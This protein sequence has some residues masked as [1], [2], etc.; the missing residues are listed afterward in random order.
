MLGSAFLLC[1]YSTCWTDTLVTVYHKKQLI[2]EATL[3]TGSKCASALEAAQ[4]AISRSKGHF[5]VI[6]PCCGCCFTRMGAGWHSGSL[7][8]L[9]QGCFVASQAVVFS[10]GG[11]EQGG[12][13]EKW[14]HGA[15]HLQ[16]WH[17]L[18][19]LQ[20]WRKLKIL[21]KVTRFISW[22]AVV[23]SA[24]VSHLRDLHSGPAT[25]LPNVFSI[26]TNREKGMYLGSLAVLALHFGFTD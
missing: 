16:I 20:L 21:L 7:F 2:A 26:V 25:T 5:C 23:D 18:E 14:E 8:P 10:T 6:V 9:S 13:W 19:G 17:S 24:M 15:L 12:D 1:S 22:P 11:T 4:F 3:A